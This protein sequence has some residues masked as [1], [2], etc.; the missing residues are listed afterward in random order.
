MGIAALFESDK[1][2]TA[3]KEQYVKVL[4]ISPDFAPA[5]NNLAWIIA[6]EPDGDMGEA[7]RLA[8]V[9]KQA[10]PDEPHIADTLGWVHSQRGSPTLAIPQFELALTGRPDD[11][12]ITYHL[13]LA[14][15]QDGQKEKALK[16]VEAL[17][18]KDVEFPDKKDAEALL[19]TLRE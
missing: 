1:N 11:P 19:Q 7:L 17:L 18:E 14:L 15:N 5:A 16:V 10:L 12:T 3:A 2:T 6:S 4:E 9:A 8:M 13:A